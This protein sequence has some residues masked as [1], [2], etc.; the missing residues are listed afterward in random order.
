MVL[1]R[2]AISSQLDQLGSTASPH[3]LFICR[4][5][6]QEIY[7]VFTIALILHLVS[8]LFVRHMISWGF[9]I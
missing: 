7:V 1:H 3:V 5:G 4:L 8:S 9:I 6:K 2:W